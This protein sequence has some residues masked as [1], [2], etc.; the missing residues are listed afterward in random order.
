MNRLPLD[1]LERNICM[2]LPKNILWRF[3]QVNKSYLDAC[4]KAH[5]QQEEMKQFFY[6]WKKCEEEDHS[7][8]SSCISRFIYLHENH[9]V[10]DGM[11]LVFLHNKQAFA[12]GQYFNP[13]ERIYN[14]GG[15]KFIHGDNVFLINIPSQAFALMCTISNNYK[16]PYTSQTIDYKGYLLGFGT[17]SI[18]VLFQNEWMHFIEYPAYFDLEGTFIRSVMTP[19]GLLILSFLELEGRLERV[20]LLDLEKGE[21]VNIYWTG[22]TPSFYAF[23]LHKVY[24][25]NDRT[26][27]LIPTS[28][29]LS[30]GITIMH[31]TNIEGEIHALFHNMMIPDPESAN[32]YMHSK[33]LSIYYDNEEHAIQ[34]L[35]LAY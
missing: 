27:F 26:V 25:A 12:L 1:L 3:A 16:V 35:I 20:I 33:G 4:R 8:V 22:M 28:D 30:Y 19:W 11:D 32:L 29:Y 23:T 9:V 15:N 21:F 24:L 5:I 7:W 34:D 13:F 2:K 6:E 18:Q 17:H 10:F 14:V 31:L